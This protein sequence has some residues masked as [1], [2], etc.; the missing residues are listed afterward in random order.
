MCVRDST[1]ASGRIFVYREAALERLR[2]LIAKCAQT[3]RE[4]RAT[5]PTRSSELRRVEGKTLRGR[6]KAL[7]RSVDD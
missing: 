5:K 2:E 4:R 7:R 1:H 6:I 3:P